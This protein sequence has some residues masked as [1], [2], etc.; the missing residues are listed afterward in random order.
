MH[1]GV[2][3]A[4]A[5]IVVL[6]F[7]EVL[8][9][10]QPSEIAALK[11]QVQ[12]LE[13][14]VAALEDQIAALEP[15]RQQY[16]REKAFRKE[17]EDLGGAPGPIESTRRPVAADTVLQSGQILQVEQCKAWWA[18][19]VLTLLPN[20]GVRVHYLGWAPV[21][22]EVVPR[23]RLQ[24][25]PEAW[26]KAKKAVV[27]RR[28]HAYPSPPGPIMPSDISV[29]PETTLKNGDAVQV[30]WRDLWWAG[31][32]LSV[33]PDGSVKIHYTGWEAH[34]DEAVPRSRLRLPAE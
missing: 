10:Q 16:E 25:D 6:F 33:L 31:S 4:C 11:D 27:Q 21:W 17:V 5:G 12:R 34:W 26:S 15:V 20:G 7:V 9:A 14:K 29:K 32:V 8:L 19:K 28:H 18:G 1:R 3:L 22:D 23:A 30:E 24:L 2:R 13:K